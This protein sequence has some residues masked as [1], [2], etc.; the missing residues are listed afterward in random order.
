MIEI[1]Q[2]SKKFGKLQVLKDIN[3]SLSS[4]QCISLIG[5]NGSGKTTLIKSILGMVVPSSGNI[6]FDG[7]NINKEWTYRNDIGY[8]PQ[9]GQYP[10]NMRIGQVL[11][12]MRDIRKT[13]DHLLDNELYEKF[14]LNNM[15]DKRMRTLSGG[16][17]QKVSACLAFMFDPKV[18]ILD[19]PTAGLDP[20]ATEILKE[21]IAHEKQKNKL[22]LITSHVLSD[23]DELVSQIIY[24]QDGELVFHKSLED[25]KSDTG[26]DKLSKAIAHIMGHRSIPQI[27]IIHE[28]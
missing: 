8:M 11:D 21:K 7:K 26:T 15:L 18:L 24:M 25:L 2:L 4:G 9:I 10:E 6:L 27:E 12:M 1:E 23:L 20:L 3:L 19:E 22:I 14:A 16:T 28:Q 5:P 17:R 13:P